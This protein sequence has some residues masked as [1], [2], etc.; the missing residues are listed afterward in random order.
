MPTTTEAKKKPRTKK[1]PEPEPKS[2]AGKPKVTNV[3]ILLDSSGSMGGMRQE[4]VDGF[5]EQVKTLQDPANKDLG[6][7]VG[8][9]TFS[10]RTHAAKLWNK[11]VSALEPLKV[12]E[13]QPDG[14]TALLDAIGQTIKNMDGLPVSPLCDAAYLLVIITDGQ[15]NNSKEYPWAQ[16]RE[17]IED[18]QR[19]GNWTFSFL[20]ANMNVVEVASQRLGI[21][22]GNVQAFAST[23]GGL[24]T[25]YCQTQ[26]ALR[27]YTQSR[28]AGDA[29]VQDFYR[30][31]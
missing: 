25:A 13:Y 29:A 21:P 23:P 31:N 7:R 4:A 28:R 6:Y 11:K 17:M 10:T 8:L 14:M 22:T 19:R 16:V 24:K 18:R 20:G 12:E 9:V 5:N 3:V 26:G 30:K 2:G 27:S 15:E 1:K